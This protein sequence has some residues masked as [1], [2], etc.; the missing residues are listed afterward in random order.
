[1]LSLS[2]RAATKATLPRTRPAVRSLSSTSARHAEM[3]QLEVDGVPV[4]IEQG[5]SI[6][7]ACEKAGK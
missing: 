6:I 7:Q 5:S 2:R 4:E 3:I 1:M